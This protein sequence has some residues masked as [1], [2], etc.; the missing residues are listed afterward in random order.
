[1]TQDKSFHL[2]LRSQQLQ[3][4]DQGHNQWETATV[5]RKGE[6]IQVRFDREVILKSGDCLQLQ[7]QYYRS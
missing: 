4:D 1:M 6:R 2:R 3:L 7:L 5:E